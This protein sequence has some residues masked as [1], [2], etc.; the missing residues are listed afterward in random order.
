MKR[1]HHIFT[2]ILVSLTLAIAG[3]AL[4]VKTASQKN[5]AATAWGPDSYLN[6]LLAWE[7]KDYKNAARFFQDSY[8]FN[9]AR[10]EAML[11]VL[12]IKGAGVFQSAEVGRGYAI[13]TDQRP[14]FDAY[15]YYL[16]WWRNT[17]DPDYAY[18]IAWVLANRFSGQAK[19]DYK[20]WIIRAAEAGH[21]EARW[22]VATYLN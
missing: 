15:T 4:P 2:A 11:G 5:V 3:C 13:A 18:L 14:K 21:A 17:N 1:S 7:R 16:E 6:G 8:R 12:Y 20:K 9:N 19:E 10:A 22:E